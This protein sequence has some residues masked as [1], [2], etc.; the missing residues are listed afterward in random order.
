MLTREKAKEAIERKINEPDPYNQDNPK[1]VVDDGQTIEKDW[2]WVFFYNSID[3]LKSGDFIDALVG[4]A[5]YIV[6]KNTGEIL[7][8]GTAYDIEYY[9]EKYESKL[10]NGE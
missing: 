9:I 3:F 8:T 10:K 4:N 1:L 7:E 6:N 5:P 2:G